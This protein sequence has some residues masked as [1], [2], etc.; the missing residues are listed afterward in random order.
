MSSQYDSQSDSSRNQQQRPDGQIS[1]E[2]DADIMKVAGKQ[3][4]GALHVP[5]PSQ[6]ADI[7]T[8]IW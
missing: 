2:R 1:G 6:E 4:V 3:S 5:S 7:L 8:S